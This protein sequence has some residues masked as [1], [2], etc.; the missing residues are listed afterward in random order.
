MRTDA[1]PDDAQELPTDE[2]LRQ[3]LAI[4]TRL[5]DLVRVAEERAARQIDAA[6][7]ARDR[8]LVEARAAAAR[9][10]AARSR[11]ERL[12]HEQA[13]AAIESDHQRIVAAINGLSEERLEELARWAVDR[14]IDAGGETP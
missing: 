6:R 1:R 8:R 13:L 3:L 14:V 9:A 11:E 10:D 5:Q 12:A 2:R 4:E 7:D